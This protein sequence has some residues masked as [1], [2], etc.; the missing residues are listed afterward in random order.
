MH[1]G[2]DVVE[3]RAAAEVIAAVSA[4]VGPGEQHLIARG[5]AG[6]QPRL[7]NVRLVH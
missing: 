2:D 1:L 5:S 4:A 3:R 7:I 6:D